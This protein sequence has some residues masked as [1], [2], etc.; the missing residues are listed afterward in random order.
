MKLS[1]LTVLAVTFFICVIAVPLF[2]ALAGFLGLNDAPGPLKIHTRPIP[3]TGGIG[4]MIALVT[5]LLVAGAL[6]LPGAWSFVVALAAVWLIGLIDD[7]QGLSVYVRLITE[8][9]AVF[10]LWRG[11]WRLPMFENPVLS[12]VATA[13]FVIFFINAFNMLDGADG[14]TAGVTGIIAIGYILPGWVPHSSIAG[15]V[16]SGLLASCAGFLLFNFPP[17]KLFLGD[18]GS[19]TLGFIVACL[20]LDSYRGAPLTASIFMAPLILAGLPLC[21]AGITIVRR[22]SAGRSPFVGDRGHLYDLLLQRSWRPQA[23]ACVYYVLTALLLSCSLFNNGTN[24]SFSIAI[25]GIVLG[26]VA[27]TVCFLQPDHRPD[28]YREPRNDKVN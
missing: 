26:S 15:L 4:T 3:R 5:G 13:L 1:Q 6:N 17:A 7:R 10:L 14:L 12:F 19:T 11:G 2:G 25:G 24:P 27:V 28:R 16:A 23:V 22:L 18:S 21:D 20:T 9:G 8:A